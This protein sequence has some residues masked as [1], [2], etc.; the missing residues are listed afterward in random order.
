M[1]Q[2][3]TLQHMLVQDIVGQVVALK[4]H[5][6]RFLSAVGYIAIDKVVGHCTVAESHVEIG[7]VDRTE[8]RQVVELGQASLNGSCLVNGGLL[9][10][11]ED[12]SLVVDP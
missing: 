12:L 8:G 7:V 1:A 5:L 9:G 11:D 4:K 2:V 10:P 3:Q 6:P